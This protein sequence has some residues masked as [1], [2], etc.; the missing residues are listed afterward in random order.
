MGGFWNDLTHGARVLRRDPLYTGAAI[1]ALGLGIGATSALF[2]VVDAALIRKLPFADPDRL[3]VVWEQNLERGM[4]FMYAA[5]P[6]FDDWVAETT[7]FSGWGAFSTDRH[8][9]AADG[10]ATA[11][12]GAE[13]TAGLFGVLGAGTVM[14]RVFTPEDELPGGAGVVLISHTL[15]QNRFGAAP[16]IVGRTIDVDGNLAEVVGVMERGFSFPPNIIENRPATGRTDIWLPLRLGQVAEQRGAHFLTVVGRLGEGVSFDQAVGDVRAVADRASAAYPAT[17]EGWSATAVPLREQLAGQSRSQL[18]ILLGSVGLVLLIA[19]VNVANLLLARG[20][21]RQREVAVRAAIGAS[22]GRLVQQLLTESVLLG[23]LGGV[24]GLVLARIAL[25]TLVG[26][27]PESVIGA[28]DAALDMRAVGF[29]FLVSVASAVLFGALPAFTSASVALT[30]H[31]KE[32]GRS[33]TGSRGRKRLQSLLVGGE[34]AVSLTLL[35]G[36]GLLFQTFVRL[37]A[38]DVGVET[39]DTI[40]GSVALPDARYPD[41]ASQVA[42]YRELARGIREHPAVEAVG[43]IYDVPLAADRQGTSITLRGETD[44]PD[45]QNR[46]VGFSIVTAGYFDAMGIPVVRGRDFSALDLPDGDTVLIVNQALADQFFSGGDPLGEIVGIMG[47]QR[48]ISPWSGTMSLVASAA[49]TVPEAVSGVRDVIE[50]FD[51]SVPLYDVTTM[52]EVVSASADRE[53]FAATLMAVF[54]GLALLL[55]AVGIFGVVSHSVARRR[56][57]TGIR[58]ALGAA[59]GDVMRLVVRDSMRPVLAGLAVGLPLAFATAQLLRGSLFGVASAHPLTYVGVA[60]LLLAVS[61]VA[62]WVP[63]LWATRVDP[64][65]ALR[66]D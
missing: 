60:L 54:A 24:L 34:V 37:M 27:A 16:D 12:Q 23:L 2:S 38:V 22:K 64:A 26:L 39:T 35:V 3:V 21:G 62:A 19:C 61:A 14:G 49:N 4:P 30:P 44:V 66:N 48:R 43:F 10:R 41:G 5:P 31:L 52:G 20:A 63:A 11:L 1:L 40:T 28:A 17:N 58:M 57:E 45:N 46:G 18:F 47:R 50:R 33:D 59:G 53:R 32:G 55:T 13:V 42:A 29:T 9:I 51:S 6:N 25:G 8:A 15:W 56:R 7:T 65:I 36:A